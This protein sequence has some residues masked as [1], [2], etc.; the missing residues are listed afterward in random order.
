M[1]VAVSPARIE[2]PENADAMPPLARRLGVRFNFPDRG[3]LRI[4]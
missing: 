4:R 2:C 3:D 1:G